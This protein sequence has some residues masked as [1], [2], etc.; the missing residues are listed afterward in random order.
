MKIFLISLISLVLMLPV[1]GCTSLEK[2]Q[3]WNKDGEKSGPAQQK[4]EAQEPVSN[5]S[6]F[7]IAVADQIEGQAKL[8]LFGAENYAEIAGFIER[9]ALDNFISGVLQGEKVK[10]ADNPYLV[11]DTTEEGSL[12]VELTQLEDQIIN[13]NPV[14]WQIAQINP[15]N[16]ESMLIAVKY[17]LPDGRKITADK[18]VVKLQA[19]EW[20]IDFESFKDSFAKV[21]QFA[22]AGHGP[23][24]SV[25]SE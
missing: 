3:F 23:G 4:E 21:A 10:S 25:N 22:A 5:S 1:S 15:V 2:M 24:S 11:G 7:N 16:E 13:V 19:G 6:N 20:Y 17:Y 18:F 12:K 9:S 14:D 8:T